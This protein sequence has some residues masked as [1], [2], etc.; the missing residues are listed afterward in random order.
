MRIRKRQ[1]DA[2]W[3]QWKREDRI[4]RQQRE[5]EREERER[6]YFAEL[7]ARRR[8]ERRQARL[9]AR[10]RQEEND[11][12]EIDNL[13]IDAS[14]NKLAREAA[15]LVTE[16]EIT[17]ESSCSIC[18]EGESGDAASLACGHIF[19]KECLRKWLKNKMRC[20]LCNFKC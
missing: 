6:V 8:E 5:R 14:D 15:M 2:D 1:I 9:E 11:Q 17:Q 19:H 18:L 3:E 7:H 10:R 16:K 20:P 13:F 12:L 4:R